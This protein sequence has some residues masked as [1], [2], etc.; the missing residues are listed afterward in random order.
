MQPAAGTQTDQPVHSS[1]V[2]RILG[3]LQ[4]FFSILKKI[5]GKGQFRKN[6][7]IGLYS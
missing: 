3:Y 6:Y 2:V 1:G 7:D 5:P 4:E